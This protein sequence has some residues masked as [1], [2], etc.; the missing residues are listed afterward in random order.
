[1]NKFLLL[2][3]LY[4]DKQIKL[5]I[6][7]EDEPFPASKDLCKD[8]YFTYGSTIGVKVVFVEPKYEGKEFE[9]LFITESNIVDF[10]N[11]NQN[12]EID[13]KATLRFSKDTIE[14]IKAH[15]KSSTYVKSRD[16]Y[17]GFVG[18]NHNYVNP[19]EPQVLESHTEPSEGQI[20]MELKAVLTKKENIDIKNHALPNDTE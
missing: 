10:F 20:I 2:P 7:I 15:F 16:N 5:C 3:K 8:F 12:E 19:W 18:F 4:S 14:T 17:Q 1:M 6:K 9:Y 13:I 11:C